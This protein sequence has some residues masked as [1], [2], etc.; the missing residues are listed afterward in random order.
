MGRLELMTEAAI[1]ARYPA[2]VARR[3]VLEEFG[4][5]P[6]GG[7]S[8]P[9]VAARLASFLEDLHRKHAGRRV[10]VVAHDAV[11]LVIRSIVDGLSWEEVARIAATSPIRNAS[12][13]RF[14]GSSGR[15]ILTAYNAVGHLP[16]ALIG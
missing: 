15:L 1:A 2:E 9:D 5:R 11:V 13:T 16:T 7:E 4:Y 12:V 6:P 10:I 8:F 3:R 14:D